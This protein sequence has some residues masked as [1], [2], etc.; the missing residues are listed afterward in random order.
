MPICCR[1]KGCTTVWPNSV[2]LSAH[3]S[4]A[5]FC[6]MEDCSSVTPNIQS[7]QTHIRTYHS[8]KGHVEK[9]SGEF[10]VFLIKLVLYCVLL[11]SGMLEH[12]TGDNRWWAYKR[13]WP[14]EVGSGNK[15]EN[16][17][18]WAKVPD[19][20]LITC[21]RC[22]RTEVGI[23]VGIEIGPWKRG[24]G[25]DFWSVI[26]LERWLLYMGKRHWLGLNGD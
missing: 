11:T 19:H 12:F 17:Q 15:I 25:S 8:E 24:V 4:A 13:N 22:E 5:H 2:A 14:M 9:D 18:I 26:I 20:L 21:S 10:V 6:P 16:F 7:M 3:Q 1:I 23:D